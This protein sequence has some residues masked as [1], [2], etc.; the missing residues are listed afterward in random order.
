MNEELADVEV[1][2]GDASIQTFSYSSNWDPE[3]KP[4][5]C[6]QIKLTVIQLN[7]P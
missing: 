4:E 1:V 3:D 2:V 5:L 7:S 6:N